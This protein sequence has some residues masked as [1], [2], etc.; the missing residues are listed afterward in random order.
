MAS[1][2]GNNAERGYTADERDNPT[3][4]IN[5]H[6]RLLREQYK[7]LKGSLNKVVEHMECTQEPAP[8][9]GAVGHAR[10][11]PGSPEVGLHWKQPQH[12]HHVQKLTAN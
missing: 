2:Q 4:E 10:S 3:G 1:G 12:K 5:S 6:Y 7:M 8:F 11:G 9:P